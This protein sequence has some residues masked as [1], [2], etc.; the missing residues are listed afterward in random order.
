LYQLT[1]PVSRE[2]FIALAA[3]LLQAQLKGPLL[4]STNTV[5]QY[6][7]LR[8]SNPAKENC[9]A[10]LLDANMHLLQYVALS[11]GTLNNNIV[12]P[13]EIAKLALE[14]H[15]TAVIFSHNHPSGS[16]L[17]APTT[18]NSPLRCIAPLPC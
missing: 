9:A 17:L 7:Q 11:E 15:A 8:L 12:Y 18:Y 16:L 1:A 13:R 6:L 2:E 3:S 4:N 5:G 14:H 10:L